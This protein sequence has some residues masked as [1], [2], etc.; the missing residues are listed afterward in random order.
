MVLYTYWQ[1]VFWWFS[2][3]AAM[4]WGLRFPFH[5]HRFEVTG[6]TKYIHITV[7]LIGLFLPIV[8][9]VAAVGTGGFVMT[10]FPPIICNPKSRETAFYALTLP[11]CFMAVMGLTLLILVFWT[12]YKVIFFAGAYERQKGSRSIQLHRTTSPLAS[13]PGLPRTHKRKQ[14]LRVRGRPG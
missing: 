8:P 10:R 9:V 5:A 4:F 1:L 6:K 7:I 11:T 12:I 2:H 13:H 14:T 3:I